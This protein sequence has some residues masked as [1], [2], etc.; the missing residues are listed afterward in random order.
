MCCEKEQTEQN[1]VLG[2]FDFW[3]LSRSEE[4]D[5]IEIEVSVMESPDDCVELN[6]KPGEPLLREMFPLIL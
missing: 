3:N 2:K 6:I 5:K 1:K 4:I